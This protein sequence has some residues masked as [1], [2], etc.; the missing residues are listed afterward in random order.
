MAPIQ[1]N[2]VSEI[3]KISTKELTIPDRGDS[4]SVKNS[5]VWTSKMIRKIILSRVCRLKVKGCKMI[6]FDLHIT[7]SQLIISTCHIM[8]FSEI[9]V[10][11]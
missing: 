11:I 8:I 9:I 1:S 3:N 6:Q 7:S 4:N 5:K 2:Y 10:L